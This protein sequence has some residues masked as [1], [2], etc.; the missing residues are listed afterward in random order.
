MRFATGRRFDALVVALAALAGCRAPH[1]VRDVEYSPLASYAIHA[2]PASVFREG[3]VNPVVPE[4]AGP[5]SV[6]EYIRFALSQNP[7]IQATRKMVDAKWQRV[8]QM[9]SLE[10]PTLSAM[11]WPSIP[12]A[13]QY[14]NGRMTADVVASQKVPWRGTLRTQAQA[15]REDANVARAQLASAE[16]EVIEKVRRAYYEPLRPPSGA[17]DSAVNGSAREDTSGSRIV[18]S[19]QPR[20]DSRS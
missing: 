11:G 14:V 7:S 6:D 12:H 3:V 1:R 5:H 9:S 4:L 20:L 2:H 13:P 10:D 15:A 19:R 8:P 16:L 18:V 17:S